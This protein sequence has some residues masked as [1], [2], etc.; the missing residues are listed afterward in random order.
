VRTMRRITAAAC[1]APTRNSGCRA[2]CGCC[3][4]P[5]D[6]SGSAYLGRSSQF[7]GAVEAE[8]TADTGRCRCEVTCIKHHRMIIP[9]SAKQNNAQS[10][11]ASSN[12]RKSDRDPNLSAR[13][14]SPGA[15]VASLQ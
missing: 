13:V 8:V 6:I 2:R 1:A 4:V 15:S 3:R 11:P 12:L 14:G 5:A 10:R 9:S 7:A